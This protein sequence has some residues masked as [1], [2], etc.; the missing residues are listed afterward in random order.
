[1][2]SFFI[3]SIAL[4][5][6]TL[7]IPTALAITTPTST[8]TGV[9]QKV[10]LNPPFG[11]AA[12]APDVFIQTMI[13]RII[14]YALGIVGSIALLIFVAGGFIWLTSAGNADRIKSGKN[15]IVWA[16]IGLAVIFSAYAITKFILTALLG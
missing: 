8:D 15:M 11:Q 1:M 10:E 2:K 9:P 7:L 5:A 12:A 4:F 6:L 13:G 3:V 14:Q 16:V